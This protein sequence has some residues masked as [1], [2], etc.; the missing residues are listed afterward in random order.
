[1]KYFYNLY[2]LLIQSNGIIYY[3]KILSLNKSPYLNYFFIINK[4]NKS[5]IIQISY[6]KKIYII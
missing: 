4:T 5:D 6:D 3:I 2:T 1:M